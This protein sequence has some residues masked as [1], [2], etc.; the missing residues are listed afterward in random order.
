MDPKIPS[1]Q[2]LEQE[3]VGADDEY[4]ED[5][6]D[7]EKEDNSDKKREKKNKKPKQLSV[8]Q[9]SESRKNTKVIF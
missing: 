2:Q 1:C 8:K 7:D 4:E 5:E 3:D 6:R 9:T